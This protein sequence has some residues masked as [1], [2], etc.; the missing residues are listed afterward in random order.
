MKDPDWMGVAEAATA[1]GVHENSVRNW[2]DT[3]QLG[4]VAM[5]PGGQRSISRAAV[6]KILAERAT[7]DL[8]AAE[9]RYRTA[10]ADL[11]AAVKRALSLLGED[12]E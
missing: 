8:V 7:T 3:G 12:G 2:A 4:P 10:R 6:E 11:R 5:S 1:L 9:E